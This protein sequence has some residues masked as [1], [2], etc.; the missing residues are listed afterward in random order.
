MPGFYL[1]CHFPII[2]VSCRSDSV[3]TAPKVEAHE[4]LR[5]LQVGNIQ[6]GHFRGKVV[7]NFAYANF[8]TTTLSRRDRAHIYIRHL[9]EITNIIGILNQTTRLRHHVHWKSGLR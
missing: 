6:K 2:R 9:I 1:P 3:W 7:L 5:H 8:K 4:D